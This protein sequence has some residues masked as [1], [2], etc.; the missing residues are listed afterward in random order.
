MYDKPWIKSYPPGVRW[1]AEIPL[2][3]VQQILE[4]SAS[5]WPDNPAIDFMGRKITYREL[6]DLARSSL[7]ARGGGRHRSC[8]APN[9]AGPRLVDLRS[10]V[11]RARR[12]KQDFPDGTAQAVDQRLE[13]VRRISSCGKVHRQDVPFLDALVLQEVSSATMTSK[14]RASAARIKSWKPGCLLPSYAAGSSG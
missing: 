6:D 12:R 11:R 2:T 14:R 3:P 5:K 8:S 7:P 4:E 9:R 13:V 10:K 1:D